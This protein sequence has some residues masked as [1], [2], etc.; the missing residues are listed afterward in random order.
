MREYRELTAFELESLHAF[1]KAHG[2]RW[3]EEL[4]NVYWYNAR[5][6][7][8]PVPGMGNQLHGIR[9]EFGPTWL[10]DVFKLPKGFQ[11]DKRPRSR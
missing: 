2:R 5:I 3:R 9:N 11:F 4:G 6:W 10:W 7:R 8:G 1:A